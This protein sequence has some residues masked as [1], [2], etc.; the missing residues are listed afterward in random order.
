[1]LEPLHKCKI[2]FLIIA[3]YLLQGIFINSSNGIVMD[4]MPGKRE[5]KKIHF[6]SKVI[7]EHES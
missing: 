7:L 3:L 2:F 4:F 1:M 6:R 5:K